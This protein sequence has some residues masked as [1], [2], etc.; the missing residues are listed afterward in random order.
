[1]PQTV[2]PNPLTLEQ[3]GY[4]LVFYTHTVRPHKQNKNKV[5]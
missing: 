4:S 2:L 3:S 1:M 5:F